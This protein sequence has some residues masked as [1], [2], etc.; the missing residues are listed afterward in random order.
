MRKLAH[1]SI[2]AVLAASGCSDRR[3]PNIETPAPDHWVT[4]YSTPEAY[5]IGVFNNPQRDF[6]GRIFGAWRIHPARINLS[7]RNVEWKNGEAWVPVPPETLVPDG[8]KD[9]REMLR[10]YMAT[11]TSP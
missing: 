9:N 10:L 2:L 11:T 1:I 4:K 6:F 7:N 3:I 5:C 8:D